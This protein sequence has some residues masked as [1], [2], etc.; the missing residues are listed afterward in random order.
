M[1][2]I[3]VCPVCDHS[4]EKDYKHFDYNMQ[5]KTKTEGTF[6]FWSCEGQGK[7]KKYIPLEAVEKL[8]MERIKE[9]EKRIK[10]TNNEIKIVEALCKKYGLRTQ[11]RLQQCYGEFTLEMLF[12]SV[13]E[14]LLNEI[15]GMK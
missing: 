15:N 9:M 6:H 11:D 12:K 1:T 2:P 7:L 14:S 4:F 10:L 13:L 3:W 5:P 8:V